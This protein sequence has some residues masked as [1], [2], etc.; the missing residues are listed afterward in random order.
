[1]IEAGMAAWLAMLPATSTSRDVLILHAG[2]KD[3]GDS[4]QMESY[5][6]GPFIRNCFV[7]CDS[8]GSL[9]ANV[10]TDYHRFFRGLSISSCKGGVIEGNQIHNTWYGGPYLAKWSARG[11][12]ARNNFYKNV[13][14]GP[15]LNLPAPDNPIN[16]KPPNPLNP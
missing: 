10:S 3:Y 4:N 11:I 16:L 7:D 15:F 12:V 9:G 6:A 14:T 5:G 1:M 2:G 8:T 13:V